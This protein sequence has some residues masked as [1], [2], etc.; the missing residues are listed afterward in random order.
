MGEGT[1]IVLAASDS[2]SSEFQ[3]SNWRQMLL[4]ALPARYARYIGPDWSV[5][6]DV[7]PDGQARYVPQGLRIVES[8]LLRRFSAEDVVVCYPD[9]LDRFVGAN[10]RVIGL[11]AHNPLGATFTSDSY[12]HF[13]G[14][15]A[16]PINAYEFRRMILH[17]AIKRH[18]SHLK[19]IVGGPGAWQIDRE[20]VQ[21]EWGVDC[22]VDGEAEDIALQLFE[23]GIRGESLPRIVKGHSPKLAS[24][25]RTLHRATFGGVEITRGCGRGCQFCSVALRAGNSI[26]LDQILHNVRIQTAEGGDTIMLTTEDLFLYEQGRQFRTN[27]QALKRLFESI[28]AVDGVKH[29]ILSHA[30]L[31][32]VVR[33]PHV[34]E[35][36]TPLVVGMSVHQHDAS[37]HTDK[38]Y[39]SMIVG[40][41]TGSSRLLNETM[42]G[43]AYPF[44]PHQWPDVVLKAMETL[45]KHNW[46]PL[47][48]FI[49]GLPGETREDTK[50]SLDLLFALRDA[51]WCV[52]PALFV[53]MDDT[54]LAGR[55]RAK[56]SHFTDLQW[57]FFFT[58]WRYNLD[59]FR[60]TPGVQ[61]KYNA[62]APL[63][64]YLMGR[65]LFGS[66]IK[67]PLF[68]LGH[69]PE[70][71]L[72][73]KLYLDFT[74]EST[75]KLRT[76]ESVNAPD[77]RGDLNLNVLP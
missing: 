23:T 3:R 26:P 20:G 32:P 52:I 62:G 43:K 36:L 35:E 13:Y 77:D 45:N 60:G 57:E 76:P 33:E 48:T 54:R 56:L 11:H 58:C 65:R 29:I 63:Y 70:R 19:I 41:E 9:Q 7:A 10:T 59:F 15:K 31:A 55:E 67:Y 16:E 6:N 4:A 73:R 1:R 39:A 25:P 17:P 30:T 14:A 38:R 53:P 28:A 5:K 51:K 66:A 72:R 22:L 40:I 50:Q 71:F 49:I 46:F 8:L 74:G 21:D 18:K 61:W 12:A 68:R 64:Y 47:C 27:V 75:P 37:T 69:F 24:I 42:R 2:E 34:I 44:R